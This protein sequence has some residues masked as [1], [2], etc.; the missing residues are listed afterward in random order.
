MLTT[1]PFSGFYC[2]LHESALDDAV[3]Q[4]FSDKAT[5]CT[6]YRGL[7]DRAQWDCDWGLVMRDYAEEYAG[8]FADH[9]GIRMSFES[10]TSPKEYNFTTDRIFC[11]IPLDECTRLLSATPRD[12]LDKVAA[13]MFTSRDGFMS[14]YSPD[15]STWGD[16]SEWDYNQIGC[17]ITAYVRHEEPDFD[18]Y[19]E[20]ALMEDAQCNG[21]FDSWI[22]S[23]TPT[24][25]RLYK[26]YDYL[27]Q[28]SE[29]HAYE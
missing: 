5:G 2:T 27:E 17:L 20:Y 14:F 9:F 6:V 3:E 25:D 28:R 11:H 12:L 7:A 10:M 16:L 29:R 22:S 4:M 8:Q 13:E 21:Y 18:Q 24:V 1:I 19:A 15:I 26:V 23:N